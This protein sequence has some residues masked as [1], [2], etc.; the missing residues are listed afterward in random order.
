MELVG[1]QNSLGEELLVGPEI[2]QRELEGKQESLRTELCNELG[3]ERLPTSK[4]AATLQPAAEAFVPTTEET[5]KRQPTRRLGR[6]LTNLSPEQKHVFLNVCT[7]Q[8]QIYFMKS[9]LSLIC[10]IWCYMVHT[11]LPS[12]WGLCSS[13]VRAVGLFPKVAGSISA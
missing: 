8:H 6:C 2:T 3:V 5:S 10:I 9:L 13:A 12:A 1:R 11:T 4:F 7:L